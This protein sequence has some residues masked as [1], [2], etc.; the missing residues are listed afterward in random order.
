M[1]VKGGGGDGKRILMRGCPPHAARALALRVPRIKV[2]I[3]LLRMHACACGGA[4]GGWLVESPLACDMGNVSTSGGTNT[5]RKIHYH[6]MEYRIAIIKVITSTYLTRLN[7][8]YI[9]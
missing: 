3:R 1:T 7:N 2:R 6:F 4:T 5:F 8:A 9:I